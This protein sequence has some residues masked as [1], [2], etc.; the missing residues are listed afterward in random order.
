MVVKFDGCPSCC[1]PSINIG[2]LRPVNS[3]ILASGFY[4]QRRSGPGS[5]HRQRRSAGVGLADF[6]LVRSEDR[7]VIDLLED[8]IAYSS[9]F[10]VVKVN[11]E[12]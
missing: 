12:M 4:F 1:S 8:L 6:V 2:R 3:D 10:A 7:R 5:P 9:N 11:D